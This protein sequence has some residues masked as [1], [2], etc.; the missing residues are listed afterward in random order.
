MRNV[1]PSRALV[2]RSRQLLA[3]TFLVIAVAIFMAIFGLALYQIPLVS[4][5]NDAYP[6]FNLGR[7]V[8]FIGGVIMGLVGIGLAIRAVTWKVD[9]DVARILGDELAQK[10]DKRYYLIRN[11]SRRQ[12]G[13][14]DAVLIG[15]SGV[16][17]FRVLD[18][19]G[20]FL[21]EKAKWMKAAKDGHWSPMRK[22]PSEEVIADIK[23]MKQYLELKGFEDIPVFGAIVF[24][25][26]DPIVHLTVK[27]PAVLATHLS[28]LYRR[29]QAN[30][31]AK[32]RI[33]QKIVNQIFDELYEE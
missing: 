17:V 14:I 18:M 22:N 20:K 24:I 29:L 15:P 21:N 33:D 7:G 26:D 23:S 11:I 6:V 5:T 31:L 10:L 32:E 1:A 30:Y 27:E 9:N 12:L 8:L 4:S 13:Y 16:L 19:K 28:S 25:E 2:R 3:V